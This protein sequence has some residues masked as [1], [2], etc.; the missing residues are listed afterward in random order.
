ML[1]EKKIKYFIKTLCK[2]EFGN[3]PPPREVRVDTHTHRIGG[4]ARDHRRP[5]PDAMHPETSA[6]KPEA[7]AVANT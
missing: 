4:R 7:H 3:K 5:K 6:P 2:K 1:K